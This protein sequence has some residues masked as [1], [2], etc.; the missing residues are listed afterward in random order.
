VAIILRRHQASK[1][2]AHQDLE[3]FIERHSESTAPW[4]L[5]FALTLTFCAVAALT[6]GW[7]A[8]RSERRFRGVRSGAVLCVALGLGLAAASHL[9][10]RLDYPHRH[11]GAV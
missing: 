9:L 6:V 8:A 7:L 3:S 2:L 10:F 1:K 4:R 5:T 11:R